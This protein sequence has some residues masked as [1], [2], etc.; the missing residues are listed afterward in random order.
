MRAL[1][2]SI[3]VVVAAPS[4]SAPAE[5]TAAATAITTAAA[6][7]AS[8]SATSAAGAIARCIDLEGATL[9]LPAV[10]RVD[11][12]ARVDAFE[13]D[14]REA[15]RATA[16]PILHHV[17]ADDRVPLRFEE[18]GQALLVRVVREVSN[19]EVR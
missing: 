14:E 13:L 6:A 7:S 10:E 15:A 17:H 2:R 18:L 12:R 1:T 16:L 3:A 8:T 19:V 4:A 9:E 5:T 11:H